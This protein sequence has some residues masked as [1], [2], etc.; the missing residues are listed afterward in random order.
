MHVWGLAN[1]AIRKPGPF[2]NHQFQGHYFAAR[3]LHPDKGMAIIRLPQTQGEIEA[4]AAEIVYTAQF[5][6][7]STNTTT[8]E[9]GPARLIKED[10]IVQDNLIECWL[11]R[12]ARLGA[13]EKKSLVM[14]IELTL[15]PWSEEVRKLGPKRVVTILARNHWRGARN[16]ADFQTCRAKG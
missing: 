4:A 16:A 7:W 11:Q 14:N 6:R 12:S 5:D 2:T 9:L 8:Q 10:E 15:S 1:Q 13:M 3:V